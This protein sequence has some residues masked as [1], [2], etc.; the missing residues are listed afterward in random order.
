[1]LVLK[2]AGGNDYRPAVFVIDAKPL[3]AVFIDP[4]DFIVDPFGVR[5]LHPVRSKHGQIGLVGMVEDLPIDAPADQIHK[6]LVSYLQRAAD[7]RHAYVKA[8]FL[9]I[10]PLRMDAML[11]GQADE[12]R[13][14]CNQQ[15][16]RQKQH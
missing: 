12:D 5:E 14:S 7:R 10:G 13:P 11:L 8:L 6:I 16:D 2:T 9:L 3:P 4:A 1:M 15:S